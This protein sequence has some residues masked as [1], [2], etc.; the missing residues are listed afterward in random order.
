MR[1]FKGYKHGVDLGGWLSQSNY[2]KEH[3]ENFIT[4]DDIARIA[5]WGL[6]HVRLP[7]DYNIMLDE[8]N[9]M[10]EEA[11]KY[12]DRCVGWCEKHGLNIILDLHKTPGFSFDKGEREDG[13]FEKAEYQDI[14]VGMWIEL[15]KHYA[16]KADHV[17]FELLNEI[18]D[19]KYAEPWNG[20]AAR[21]ICEIQRYAPDTYILVG[22]IFNNSIFG[23]TLLDKPANDK[24]VFNFHYYNP[25][26]FT[27]QKAYWVDNMRDDCEIDYPDTK[28]VYRE[29]SLEY[30]GKDFAESFDDFS[31]EEINASFMDWEMSVAVEVAEK[32]NVPLY[33]GEYGVIDRVPDD[34]LLRWYRD[35]SSVFNK[36]GIGR[37]AWTYR[38][39]DFGIVDAC[40][41]KIADEIVKCL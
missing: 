2:E 27:H 3:L 12:L 25:I 6:D 28:A 38:E 1:E 20:I 7:F 18:T 39:K 17:A 26:V 14:F 37:A 4:E 30:V 31:G 16:D 29:K 21:T 8:N 33:C 11:F 34:S 5:G 24:I 36:Y 41:S 15:A 19:R 32:M 9:K 10:C 23:L 22:G 40:R 35:I 13:F